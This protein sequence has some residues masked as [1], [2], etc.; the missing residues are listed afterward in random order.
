MRGHWGG[1]DAGN[2]SPVV[3][4]GPDYTLYS[5]S[6]PLF[7][8]HRDCSASMP[9]V[10]HQGNVSVVLCCVAGIWLQGD[11]LE[12]LVWVQWTLLSF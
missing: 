11:G 12:T 9:E 1:E 7:Q 5:M 8:I 3:P 4:S 6:T 10:A 2:G